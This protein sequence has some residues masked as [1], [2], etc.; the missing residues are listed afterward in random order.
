MSSPGMK[1]RINKI[2]YRMGLL[3]KQLD[4]PTLLK[5]AYGGQVSHDL[6]KQAQ[7]ELNRREEARRKERA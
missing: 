2:G 6:K 7:A 5:Y 3:L 1:G 4:R